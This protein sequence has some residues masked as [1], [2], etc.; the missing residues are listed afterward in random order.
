ME[1]IQVVLEDFFV[2]RDFLFPTAIWLISRSYIW[3]AMLSLAPNLPIAGSESVFGWDV[4]DAW[5]SEHYRAIASTG[6][7]FVN[8][9]KQHNLAFFPLFPLSI[10]FL[11]FL[12]VPFTLAGILVNNLAF[13]AALYCLYFWVEENQGTEA[14]RWTVIITA[15]SPLSVFGT[16]IYTEGLYLLASTAAL[17]TFDQRKYLWTGFWGAIATAT[18]PTGLA[19]I[20]ALLLTAWQ[21]R[22][23]P[24]A[25][26][27]AVST[28]LGVIAFSIYCTIRFG[29]PTAFIQAQKGWRPSFGFDWQS[30]LKMFTEI[31]CGKN[32]WENFTLLNWLHLSIFLTS[33]VT[34]YLLWRYRQSKFTNVFTYGFYS[35]IL[36]ILLFANSWFTYN[37]LCAVTFCGGIV[38]LQ[39]YHKKLT[40]IATNYA[41]CGL[42]L[43]ISSGSVISLNRL[44]YGIIPLSVALGIFLSRHLRWGYLLLGAFAVLLGKLA[45]LFARNI[46][47]G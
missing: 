42:G 24:S 23:S 44:T 39:R 30:W 28:T 22:R 16:V 33:L 41:I 47:I 29:N 17:W 45:V 34:I 10:K 6:Y 3:I 40:P 1:K 46:W 38:V 26:L 15:W 25:Y 18:R 19:L 37:F 20:P 9:G 12:G 11:M 13:L 8:D 31:A 27:A 14:A 36:C 2:K 5:D 21:Q 43:L 35:L 32:S 4:F 7:E